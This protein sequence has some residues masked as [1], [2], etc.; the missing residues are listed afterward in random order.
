MEPMNK[1][2]S[3]GP[4]QKPPN[5]GAAPVTAHNSRSWSA[6]N[7]QSTLSRQAAGERLLRLVVRDEYRVRPSSRFYYLC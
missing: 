2:D 3:K 1:P 4:I 7:I 6:D 5:P